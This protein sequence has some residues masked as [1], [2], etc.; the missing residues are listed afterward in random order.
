MRKNPYYKPWN[1][2]PVILNDILGKI[3]IESI[4]LGLFL[5]RQHLR[6]Y[7]IIP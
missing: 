7:Y 6:F 1:K 5:V 4:G 2:L 3:S